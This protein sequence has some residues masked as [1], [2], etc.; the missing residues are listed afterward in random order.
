MSKVKQLNS[1]KVRSI[2]T[3]WICF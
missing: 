3:A 2:C 1:S